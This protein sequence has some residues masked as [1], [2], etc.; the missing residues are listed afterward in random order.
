MPLQ[1]QAAR[2]IGRIEIDPGEEVIASRDRQGLGGSLEEMLV[3]PG[4][5]CRAVTATGRRRTPG[6]QRFGLQRLRIV[7]NRRHRQRGAADRAGQHRGAGTQPLAGTERPRALQL[8]GCQGGSEFRIDD[9]ADQQPRLEHRLRHRHQQPHPLAQREVERRQ[10]GG[11]GQRRVELL[12]WQRHGI[13]GE[14]DGE[15]I[16]RH[17]LEI[18]HVCGQQAEWRQVRVVGGQCRR[19]GHRVASRGDLLGKLLEAGLPQRRQ[20]PV[21]AEPVGGTTHAPVARAS[22]AAHHA[23]TVEEERRP[24][25]IAA[26][27]R[28]RH[29][30]RLPGQQIVRSEHAFGVEDAPRQIVTP[31]PRR[32][33]RHRRQA[34]EFFRPGVPQQSCR[35]ADA[36]VLEGDHVAVS[37]TLQRARI[38]RV[39][40]ADAIGGDRLQ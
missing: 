17:G 15:E 27:Q 6:R 12:G 29:A 7:G 28:E 4:A 37:A 30:K 11:L 24:G 10:R 38:G 19:V 22:A 34:H 33:R 35:I 32:A 14:A 18:D 8:E 20:A 36:P 2:R 31:A 39:E 26:D 5:Q 1:H 13:E 9:L 23:R 25:G 16:A 21:D 3:H 40:L